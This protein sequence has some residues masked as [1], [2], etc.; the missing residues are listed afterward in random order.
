MYFTNIANKELQNFHGKVKNNFNMT[1]S[2]IMNNRLFKVENMGEILRIY[3]LFYTDRIESSNPNDN[4]IDNKC[5]IC[6][7]KEDTTLFFIVDEVIQVLSLDYS[8]YSDFKDYFVFYV[9][10]SVNGNALSNVSVKV[11]L[12]NN[13]EIVKEIEL[14][15]DRKGIVYLDTSQVS[16]DYISIIFEVTNVT[17]IFEWRA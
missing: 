8:Y 10:D 1:L 9:Y 7:N 6:E 15:S 3:P 14:T 13:D 17:K 11:T 4:I 12:K 5:I 2:E 16:F